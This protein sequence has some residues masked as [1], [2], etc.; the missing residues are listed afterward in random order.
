MDG[1]AWHGKELLTV[2]RVL[3]TKVILYLYFESYKWSYKGNGSRNPR[4][5]ESPGIL[6]THLEENLEKL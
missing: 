3:R 5:P 6:E 4:K 2:G 1:K